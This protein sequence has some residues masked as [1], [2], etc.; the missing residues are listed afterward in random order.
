MA[1]LQTVTFAIAWSE[2]TLKLNMKNLKPTN[3]KYVIYCR[4][5]KMGRRTV[6]ARY[7]P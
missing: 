6:G 7:L 3:N 4:R 5:R 2:L 1:A